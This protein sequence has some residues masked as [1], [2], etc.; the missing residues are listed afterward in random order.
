M[1]VPADRMQSPV[2]LSLGFK[3]PEKSGQGGSGATTQFQVGSL[4]TPQGYENLTKL[5]AQFQS[6]LGMEGTYEV[7][8]ESTPEELAKIQ[9]YRK[10]IAARNDWMTGTTSA[11]N[12]PLRQQW[13]NE[14][15]DFEKKIA[16]LEGQK[17]DTKTLAAQVPSDKFSKEQ[18]Q[19]D[20]AGIVN[21]LFTQ[22]KEQA[23]P[24]I[25]TP[26]VDTG[27]YNSTTGQLLANDAFARTQSQAAGVTLD[28]IL[29]YEQ[30]SLKEK[31]LQQRALLDSL[32]LLRGAQ[33][34]QTGM[35]QTTESSFASRGGSIFGSLGL[36]GK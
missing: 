34:S 3:G 5:I 18:A 9:E 26:M 15:A 4:F 36:G 29:N 22:Y 21:Q 17:F 16:E 24:Q 7:A 11:R 23:L 25:Y 35:G 6:A 32:G 1:S 14:I 27:I 33:T 8:R 28:A 20:V 13:R 19:A 12:E 31:E 2:S 10:E 30:L